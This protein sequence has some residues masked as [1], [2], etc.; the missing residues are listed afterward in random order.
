MTAAETGSLAHAGLAALFLLNVSQFALA[1]TLNAHLDSDISPVAIISLETR[2]TVRTPIAL[3]V[4]LSALPNQ[5]TLSED[6]F[7]V[8]LDL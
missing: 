8:C 7:Q 1:S 5:P 3:R 2:P 4:T 6:I